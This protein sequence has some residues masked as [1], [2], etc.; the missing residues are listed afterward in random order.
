M[1][2]IRA[3]L[4]T[5]FGLGSFSISVMTPPAQATTVLP[6]YTANPIEKASYANVFSVPGTNPF[7]ISSTNYDNSSLTTTGA[8][9]YSL[10]KLFDAKLTYVGPGSSGDCGSPCNFGKGVTV[11]DYW[12]GTPSKTANTFDVVE[13]V[14][15]DTATT[16]KNKW[17]QTITTWTKATSYLEFVYQYVTAVSC[18]GVVAPSNITNSK[19]QDITYTILNIF[20]YNDPTIPSGPGGISATPLPAAFPMMGTVLAGGAWFA[21][22]RRR[23]LTADAG[24]AAA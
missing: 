1:S 6:A 16:T 5:L 21:R 11:S 10:D 12:S 17:G 19:T 2:V 14:I 8:V 13:E 18:F 9:G 3:L 22:W 24:D 4:L 7:P 20:A 15:T 23:R